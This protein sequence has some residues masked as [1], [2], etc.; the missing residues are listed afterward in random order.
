MSRNMGSCFRF[1]PSTRGRGVALRRLLD[2]LSGAKGDAAFGKIVWSK[3]YRDLVTGKNADVILAHFAGD[4]G[5]DDVPIVE[6]HPEQGVGK[7]IDNRPL[8]FNAFFFC[9]V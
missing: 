8:H 1:A 3:L 6:L 7:G 2:V 4:M 9:H 5:S